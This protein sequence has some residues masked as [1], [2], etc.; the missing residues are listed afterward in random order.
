MSTLKDIFVSVCVI[1]PSFEDDIESILQTVKKTLSEHYAHY[2]ILVVD[3][4]RNTSSFTEKMDS[5]LQ[6][7]TQIRY[8]RLFQNISAK[9]LFSA[10][11]ENAIG[12]IVVVSLPKFLTPEN[13]LQSVELCCNGNDVVCG[14][15]N[16]NRSFAYSVGSWIFRKIFG[17]MISYD[18][19]KNDV[20][21]RCVSRRIINAAMNM[22]YFHEF[23]FLRLANAG[24][25]SQ[26]INLSAVPGINK[27][28]RIRNSLS[29]AI[30]MVVYNTTRPLRMMNALALFS[31]FIALMIAL[32]SIGI[33]FFRH[34]VVE[35]WTTLMFSSSF[36]LFLMFLILSTIGEYLVS[37]IMTRG[38]SRS[39]SVLFERHSSVMLNYNE[40]NIRNDSVSDNINLTQTGRD[41]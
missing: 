17:D 13:I 9:V 10:G 7:M 6:K 12:D 20:R 34:H 8:I 38:N 37:M 30:A 25:K 14:T 16:G 31:S 2:E 41:R 4:E 32:Y 33:R 26:T 36:L 1:V 23:V 18:L 21:F 35:G 15:W 19:P 27:N 22:P 40:L 29:E 5:V 3:S 39:Y 11:F 24:G 28:D